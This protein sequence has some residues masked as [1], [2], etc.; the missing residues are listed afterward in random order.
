MIRV[1]FVDGVVLEAAFGPMEPCDALRRLLTACVDPSLASRFY[2]FTAP[3]KRKFTDWEQSFYMAGFVPAARIHFGVDSK[4]GRSGPYLRPE[5]MAIVDLVSPHSPG[6]DQVHV[7][8]A[9]GN[10]AGIALSDGA[11]PSTAQDTHPREGVRSPEELRQTLAA[12]KK[13]KWLKL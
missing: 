6:S 12:G 10:G 4:G 1:E 9:S 8:G 7:I 2:L 13:P 3:P 11:G 5:L